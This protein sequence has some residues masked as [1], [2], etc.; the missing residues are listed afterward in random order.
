MSQSGSEW[1]TWYGA[2]EEDSARVFVLVCHPWA[3][4]IH[5]RIEAAVEVVGCEVW[6]LEVWELQLYLSGQLWGGSSLE[7]RGEGMGEG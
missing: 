6:G 3:A 4:Y 7:E 2:D 1:E 5:W